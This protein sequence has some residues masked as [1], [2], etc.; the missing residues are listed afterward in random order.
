MAA[1]IEAV[2]ARHHEIEQNEGDGAGVGAKEDIEGLV[3]GGGGAGLVA[4]PLDDFFENTTLG[5]IVIDDQYAL[6][7]V[8]TLLDC[9]AVTGRHHGRPGSEPIV[10]D[11]STRPH[12]HP[13]LRHFAP[14]K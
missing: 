11:H 10:R 14:A 8:I 12:G 7:H 13:S 2:G 6:G 3:T 9:Y 4:K 1:S 5:R